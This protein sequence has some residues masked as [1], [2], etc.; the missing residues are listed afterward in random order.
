MSEI[1]ENL[2]RIQ[3]RIAAAAVKAGR[4]PED[5]KLVA[6]TKMNDADRVREAIAAGL[7]AAG[8][9]RVQEMLD[10]NAL[11]AYEGA[12]LH[13]IGHLQK[14][15]VKNVVGL[16]SLIESADSPEL[17]SAISKK[18]E[19]MGICQ[20][21]LI[22][23][24]IG[25]ETAKSGVSPDKIDELLETAAGLKGISVNGLMTIPPFSDKIVET[26]NY[27]DKMYKLFIDI[28]AKKYDNINMRF[29]SMGMSGDFEEAIYA[30]ANIVRVGSAI[31]GAR[32]YS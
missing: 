9:N 15:K 11:G 3:E 4:S 26:R 10:K 17:L 14:N 22:E 25:G 13:F 5:V 2:K 7:R 20:N 6:A 32:H 30:G 24:N 1:A 18:A 31:F 29:L 27:F 21:V 16:C 28:T 19:S 8:E 23:V 12:E